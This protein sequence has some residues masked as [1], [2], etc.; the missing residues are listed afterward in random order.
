MGMTTT[1][2]TYSEAAK[3]VEQISVE[4]FQ[5]LFEANGN[6][7][8][9]VLRERSPRRIAFDAVLRMADEAHGTVFYGYCDRKGYGKTGMASIGFR[10]R[11]PIFVLSNIDRVV[12]VEV[13]V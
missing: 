11:R 13:P 5:T 8:I 4:E 1:P 3:I 10:F 7:N 12:Q 9:D 6:Y 2:R